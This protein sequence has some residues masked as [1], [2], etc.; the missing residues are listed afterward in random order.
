MCLENL[1]KTLKTK[2]FK[3]SHHLKFLEAIESDALSLTIQSKMLSLS[4]NTSTLLIAQ[5]QLYKASIVAL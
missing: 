2:M 4:K 1:H 3:T 5:A